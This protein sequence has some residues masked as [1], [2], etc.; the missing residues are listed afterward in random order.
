MSSVCVCVCPDTRFPLKTTIHIFCVS[1]FQCDCSWAM[2]NFLTGILPDRVKE[3]GCTSKYCKSVHKRK[4]KSP[5]VWLE[6]DGMT[7]RGVCS[8]ACCPMWIECRGVETAHWARM[9]AIH[10]RQDAAPICPQLTATALLSTASL[11][12]PTLQ[13][14]WKPSHCTHTVYF[15]TSARGGRQ[16][17][18]CQ[19]TRK[20]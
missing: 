12:P 20:F 8:F 15:N 4:Q 5:F 11:P 1:A 18:R 6:R 2:K 7:E 9:S 13:G 14:Q 16:P 19:S 3:T 17:S 10:S